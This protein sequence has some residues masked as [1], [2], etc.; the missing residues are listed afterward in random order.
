MRRS[1]FADFNGS[2]PVSGSGH[3]TA[4]PLATACNRVVHGH[5]NRTR[6]LPA[7]CD[8]RGRWQQDRRREAAPGNEPDRG[9]QVARPVLGPGAQAAPELRARTEEHTSELQSRLRI[10]YAILC[11]KTKNNI[12]TVVT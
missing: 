9:R 1:F 4:A 5:Q 10:S 6:R 3:W 11:C 12:S 2:A 7:G 8:R